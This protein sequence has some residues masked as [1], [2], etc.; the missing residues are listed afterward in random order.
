MSPTDMLNVPQ[1]ESKDFMP[2][3]TYHLYGYDELMGKHS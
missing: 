1:V 3:L 2:D